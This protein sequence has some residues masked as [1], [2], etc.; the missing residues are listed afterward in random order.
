LQIETK[1]WDQQAELFR[2]FAEEGLFARNLLA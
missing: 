1:D 2:R